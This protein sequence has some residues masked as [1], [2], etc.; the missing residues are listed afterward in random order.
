MPLGFM[1]GNQLHAYYQKI[2]WNRLS[3]KNCVQFYSLLTVFL[4]DL[5]LN[6]KKVPNPEHCTSKEKLLRIVIW[7]SFLKILK[8]W[9]NDWFI[10]RCMF[11]KAHRCTHI[12]CTFWIKA[13]VIIIQNILSWLLYKRPKTKSKDTWSYHTIKNILDRTSLR[14]LLMTEGYE[15][16]LQKIVKKVIEL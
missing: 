11:Y 6:L 12:V 2:F 10:R 14:T 5:V 4:I 9:M 16:F 1:L 13:N 15:S 8:T 3:F 7:H